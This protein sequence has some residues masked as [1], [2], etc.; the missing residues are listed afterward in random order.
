MSSLSGT[1]TPNNKRT[2]TGF[3]MVLK[4]L[5]TAQTNEPLLSKLGVER[6]GKKE[7]E[8]SDTLVPVPLKE[9]DQR[10]ESFASDQSSKYLQPDSSD[11]PASDI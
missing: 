5:K 10:K 4:I 9:R 7:G 11:V 2:L 8:D 6:R 1:P 3:R